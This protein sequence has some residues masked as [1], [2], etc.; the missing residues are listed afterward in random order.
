MSVGV[1]LRVNQFMSENI[2]NNH[3]LDKTRLKQV[4]DAY[5]SS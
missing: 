5:R 4:A 3:L 1:T 2:C